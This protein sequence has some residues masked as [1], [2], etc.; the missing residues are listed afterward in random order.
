MGQKLEKD[1]KRKG[2]R[3]KETRRKRKERGRKKQKEKEKV[4]LN[5]HQFKYIKYSKGDKSTKHAFVVFH[6]AAI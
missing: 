1:V 2:D 4:A 5:T 6:P 3:E